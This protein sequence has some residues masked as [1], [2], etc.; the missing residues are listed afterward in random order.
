M[1]DQGPFLS[2]TIFAGMCVVER[3]MRKKRKN[4]E[5]Y[6][7]N[8]SEFG[9]FKKKYTQPCVCDIVKCTSKSGAQ[10]CER[11]MVRPVVWRRDFFR[12]EKKNR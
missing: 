12:G 7:G 6:L 8:R 10:I 4:A 9:E 1:C 3:K 5:V 11:R 2:L